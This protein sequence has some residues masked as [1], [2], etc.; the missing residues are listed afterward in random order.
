MYKWCLITRSA[1]YGLYA[2]G[3]VLVATS[4]FH[5]KYWFKIIESQD[6][7]YVN[8]VYR[9]LRND[10]EVFPNNQQIGIGYYVTCY[11]L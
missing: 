10:I 2:F 4:E 1:F 5:V 6:H 9:M 8:I 3:G 7:K 11:H